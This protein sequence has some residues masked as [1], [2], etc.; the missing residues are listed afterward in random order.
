MCSCTR[1]SIRCAGFLGADLVN[2]GVVHGRTTKSGKDRSSIMRLFLIAFAL[3]SIAAVQHASAAIIITEVMSSS[4]HAGGSNNADWFEVTNTGASAVNITGWSWDDDSALAGTATFGSLTSI[5]AGQ[6]IIVSQETVGVANETLWKTDW[7]L[8]P[9][10]VVVNVGSANPI[11]GFSANG[12]SIFIFDATNTQVATVVFG[13]ATTG[14]SFQWDTAGNFLGVSQNGV[15]GAYVAPFSGVGV[16]AGTD[17]GSP[18]SAVTA[19]PE[20]STLVALS[21]MGVAAIMRKRWRKKS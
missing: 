11:P 14:S 20:P 16:A 13:S 4:S 21:A 12:D 1:A 5:A 17:V 10:A 18:G 6:S 15:D 2:V 3:T 8:L 19:V 9:T 7:G